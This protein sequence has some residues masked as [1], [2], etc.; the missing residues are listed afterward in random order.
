MECM[1]EVAVVVVSDARG[2]FEEAA[3]EDGGGGKAGPVSS[4]LDSSVD[5]FS[6]YLYKFSE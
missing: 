6:K 2:R 5:M 1:V 4:S 3:A